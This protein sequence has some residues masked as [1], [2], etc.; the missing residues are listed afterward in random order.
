MLKTDRLTNRRKFVSAAAIAGL[1]SAFPSLTSAQANAQI[2]RVRLGPG[3][4]LLNVAANR[5]WLTEA[6]KAKPL[7]PEQLL[8]L[9]TLYR[10]YPANVALSHHLAATAM[11]MIVASPAI[12]RA[13]ESIANTQIE[14]SWWRDAWNAIKNTFG[15]GSGGGTNCQIK[16]FFD[17]VLM[18]KCGNKSWHIIGIC[19]GGSF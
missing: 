12:N 3:G 5:E 8:R 19:I 6:E 4:E 1:A 16:C 9:A 18:E 14:W 7:T 10:D 15:G 11:G 17:S 13:M 2:P